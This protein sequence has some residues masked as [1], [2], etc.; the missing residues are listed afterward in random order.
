ME[1]EDKIIDETIDSLKEL[2]N[3]LTNL[4]EALGSLSERLEKSV[5]SIDDMKLLLKKES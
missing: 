2:E 5:K 3:S 4:N 1:Y